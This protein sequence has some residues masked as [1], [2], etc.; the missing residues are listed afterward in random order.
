ME[1]KKVL[2]EE[3]Q[4]PMQQMQIED[5]NGIQTISRGNFLKGSCTLECMGGPT[6]W[7]IPV[8]SPACLMVPPTLAA[9]SIETMALLRLI[10][11]DTQQFYITH[12]CLVGCNIDGGWV[13]VE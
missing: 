4:Q 12:L 3:R 7:W 2:H 10:L 5:L 13:P 9:S 1:S 8:E 6:S 11:C